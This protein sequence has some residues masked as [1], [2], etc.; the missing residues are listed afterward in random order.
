MKHFTYLHAW[1]NTLMTHVW[2]H[3]LKKHVYIMLVKLY[4]VYT[5]SRMVTHDMTWHTCKHLL[6]YNNAA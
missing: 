5:W 3:E 1:V 4:D 2:H 6:Y